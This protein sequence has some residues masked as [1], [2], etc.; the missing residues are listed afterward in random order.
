MSQSVVGSSMKE[1]ASIVN[2]L[3]VLGNKMKELRKRKKELEKNVLEY[4]D[5]SDGNGLRYK[6]LVVLK[7]EA[8]VTTRKNKKE[9]QEDV[10]KYL[11]DQGIGNAS[12]L[13]EEMNSLLKGT[14]HHVSKLA[15]KLE[16]PEII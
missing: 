2:E 11:E 8:T 15:L 1:L 12:K 14:K 10:V 4:L 7:K 13:Y 9:K 3:K 6:E 5:S 16:V